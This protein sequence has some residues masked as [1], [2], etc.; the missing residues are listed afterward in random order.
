MP[1]VSSAQVVAEAYM[2]GFKGFDDKLAL[3][4]VK[5][6]MMRDEFGLKYD[7]ALMQI[8]YDSVHESVAKALEYGVSDASI[9]L[10]EKKAGNT[11]DY[12][13]FNKR[14]HNYRLYFDSA[15]IFRGKDATGNWNPIF[16][17]LQNHR[18]LI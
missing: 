5:K 14:A 9:A 4:A 11:T 16:S 8:P 13:Y 18:I 2:K 10:M 17:I 6:S 3:E 15:V 7:K 1:G 12:D